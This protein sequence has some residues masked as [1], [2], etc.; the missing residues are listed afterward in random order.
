[1][2][3]THRQIMAERSNYLKRNMTWAEKRLWFGFLREYDPP[4]RPQKVV[5]NY[6]LDFYCNKVRLCIELDGESHYNSHA[7]RY[8]DIR[9]IYLNMEEI[10]V[11]RFTNLDIRESFE[12]V[13]IAID[14]AVKRRRNDL[15]SSS[16]KAL[17][18]KR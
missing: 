10:E 2:S 18:N 9:T 8:D 11:L 14:Q 4:F 17:L 12:G 13:C 16:F 6:I 7:E 5:G 1:M 15:H 3:K